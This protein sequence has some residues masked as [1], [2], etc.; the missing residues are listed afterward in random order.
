MPFAKQPAGQTPP[1]LLTGSLNLGSGMGFNLIH[2]G[3]ERSVGLRS[4][5][6]SERVWRSAL[7]CRRRNRRHRRC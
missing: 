1:F 7:H 2:I 5:P 3:R 4:M 6:A